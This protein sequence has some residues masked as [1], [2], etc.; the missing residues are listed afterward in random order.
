MVN[1]YSYEKIEHEKDRELS[2]Q[3]SPG[4]YAWYR[5]ISSLSFSDDPEEFFDEVM[6]L[7]ESPLSDVFHAQAGYLYRVSIVEKA[8]ELSK[9]KKRLLKEVLSIQEGRDFVS[10]HFRLMKNFLSPLYIGKA[11][12]IRERIGQH[13][14]GESLLKS[15]LNNAGID[16]DKC[17]LSVVYMRKSLSDEGIEFESNE[18]VELFEDIITR[19]GPSAFVRRPG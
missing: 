17:Y 5:D 3:E 6:Q 19:L 11:E 4:I 15:R 14:K 13:V 7:L 1:E 18:L 2:L 16:I 10:E 9:K 12:N 8:R